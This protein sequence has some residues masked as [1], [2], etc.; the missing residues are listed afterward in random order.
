M[1]TLI[2]YN[3]TI[4]LNTSLKTTEVNQSRATKLQS[5]LLEHVETV[6]DKGE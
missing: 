6:R 2:A 4:K 1:L 5:C 3:A